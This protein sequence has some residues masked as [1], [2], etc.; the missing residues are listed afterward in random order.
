MLQILDITLLALHLLVIS[1]NLTGWLWPATRKWHLLIVGIT[2]CS[3]IIGGFFQGF[4]YCFLTDWQWQIKRELGI[5][6]LP[7]SFIK[8]CLDSV[9]GVSF[10]PSGVDIITGITFGIIITLSVVSN[11]KF[12]RF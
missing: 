3:W 7:A 8:Y 2:A 5:G 10:D 6:D 4:G 1:F 11:R 9:T 12:L